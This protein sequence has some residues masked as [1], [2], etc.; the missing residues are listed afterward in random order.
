MRVINGADQW[1][2]LGGLRQQPEDGQPD[3]EPIGRGSRT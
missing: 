2:I 3:Q 1:L